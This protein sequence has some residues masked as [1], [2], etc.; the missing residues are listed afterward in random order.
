[1]GAPI[2]FLG[3]GW[4]WGCISFMFDFKT[5][6]WRSCQDLRAD[7]RYVTGKIKNDWRREKKSIYEYS[8]VFVICF[9]IQMY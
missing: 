1:M 3:G 4:P 5:V 9:I 8:R 7:V 6:L 2:I